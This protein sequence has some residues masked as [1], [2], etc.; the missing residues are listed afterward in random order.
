MEWYEEFGAP[1]HNPYAYKQWN[2]FKAMQES[3]KRMREKMSWHSL[4]P[5]D[6]RNVL[7]EQSLSIQKPCSV[8]LLKLRDELKNEIQDEYNANH[9]YYKAAEKMKELELPVFGKALENMAGDEFNH[10]IILEVLVD[11]ITERCE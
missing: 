5:K 10:A 4:D 8:E 7:L 6:K 9:K 11:V 3:K 2:Q 1:Q